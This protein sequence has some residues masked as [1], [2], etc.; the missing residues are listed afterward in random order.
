MILKNDSNQKTILMGA[1]V[2]TRV[3]KYMTL[4]SLAKGVS[5]SKVFNELFLDWVSRQK[6][7]DTD[8]ELLKQILARVQKARDKSKKRRVPLPDFKAEIEQELLS[9]GLMPHYVA[10]IIQEII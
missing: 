8:T 7:I 9:K 1:Y 5:K 3:H 10:I 6:E 4:Y 2:S